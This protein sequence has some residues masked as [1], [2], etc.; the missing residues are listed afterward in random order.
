MLNCRHRDECDR[1]ERQAYIYK[2]TDSNPGEDQ[3]VFEVARN[4]LRGQ[5]QR[6]R[7][8]ST[9]SSLIRALCGISRTAKLI[10]RFFHAL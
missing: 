10:E 8:S 3:A 2:E 7:N 1:E 5:K 6:E 4:Y 9:T